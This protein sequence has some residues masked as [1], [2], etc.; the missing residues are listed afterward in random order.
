[1]LKLFTRCTFYVVVYWK[2]HANVT[3]MC[4]FVDS[5]HEEDA[6]KEKC[7][8]SSHRPVYKSLNLQPRKRI[9]KVYHI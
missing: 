5:K 3:V 4:F 7:F 9:P 1:M 2:R 6:N 8:S